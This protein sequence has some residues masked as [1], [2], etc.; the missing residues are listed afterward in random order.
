MSKL[1]K[2]ILI[3]KS[4]ILKLVVFASADA[5][6]IIAAVYLSFLLRFEGQ[7][8]NEHFL[9][10]IGFSLMAL[11]I[12]LPLFYFAKL[13]SFTWLY[14][15]TSELIALAKFSFYGFLLLSAA[16]F[17]S[18]DTYFFSGFPRSTFFITYVLVFIF[19]GGIRFAKRIYLQVFARMQKGEKERV[20]IVGAGDAGEQI[21][22]NI[23][24]SKHSAHLP[25]GFVDDAIAKQGT[26]IHGLKVL[27]KIKDIVKVVKENAIEGLIIAIPSAD[28]EVI[29]AAVEQGRRAGLQKIKILP[30]I[31]EV[32][33]GRVE[34]SLLR[35][36]R[37]EELL[38]RDPVVLD[39]KPLE[40][41]IK[42]RK[43]LVTGAA[44]SIG[45]ELC[46][47]IADFNP[48]LLVLLDQ[49]E[50]GI[51]NISE[52]LKRDFPKTNILCFIA[53]IQD[54]RKIDKVFDDCSPDI[55]FHA[56]AYKHVPLM[57]EQPEEAVKNNII[58]TEVIIDAALKNN[59]EKLIFVS[60][61]KAVNPSSVMGATKRIGEML[62]QVKNQEN[63]TKL[64]SVR[65]G[66]VLG[67]RG[68]V[69]PI[70]RE[71]IEKGGPVKIT[72]SEMRRYFMTIPE[73][74]TLVMQAGVIGRGGEVFVLDM[75]DAVKIID[76][77][78]DLIRLSGLEPDKDI[79]IVFSEIRPGE[80]FFEELLTAEEGTIATQ[81]Q[82]IFMAKLSKVD[83]S[84]LNSAID[85]LSCAATIF[86]LW[87]RSGSTL[88]TS[89]F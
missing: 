42:D 38:D 71:Q 51:F 2:K 3:E 41:F 21:L 62:C 1:S 14:V 46:R 40:I 16:L 66:N 58:G 25:I 32:I 15:S 61:D 33:N 79:P 7:I 83:G 23:L 44:G 72:N 77:A 45:S 69:I 9:N 26:L 36:V 22:R 88:T 54:E 49:D 4:R 10:I 48:Q 57:E 39:E 47:Q 50:T 59:V 89:C 56:A 80:K 70:F 75:G 65:F 60:T 86:S 85:E 63:G 53:D 74:C 37:I 12:L 76:L 68:S 17:L 55:V 52:E 11:A 67:S 27:G 87:I 31:E 30:S 28:S 29:T 34:M 84:I 6:L 18:K 35:E 64:I 13:Y 24:I 78:K 73:A 8:P 20:L 43:V 82:K 19:C 81:N 5:I